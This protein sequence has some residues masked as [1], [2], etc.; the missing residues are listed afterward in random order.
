MKKP[1]MDIQL[2]WRAGKE[3]PAPPRPKLRALVSAVTDAA[4]PGLLRVSLSFLSP[5]RMAEINER[6]LGHH[7]PTDVICFDYRDAAMPDDEGDTPQVEL[8]LCPAVAA[9]EAAKRGLP[10]SR[11]LA[12]YI[13]HGFLH[14]GGFDDLKPELKRKMRAAERRVCGKLPDALSGIFLFHPDGPSGKGGRHAGPA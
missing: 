6:H 10:Y 13:V 11:E 3:F 5:K 9:R 4:C 8:F 2:S 1:E 14:A 7:G 12:L